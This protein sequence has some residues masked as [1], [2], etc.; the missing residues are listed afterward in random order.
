MIGYEEPGRMTMRFKLASN[1]LGRLRGSHRYRIM[2]VVVLLIS[3]EVSSSLC[4]T[5]RQDVVMS[6]IL[7]SNTPGI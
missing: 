1:I 5:L 7:R 3:A 4:Y 2:L 6:L